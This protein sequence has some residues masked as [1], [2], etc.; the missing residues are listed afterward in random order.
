MNERCPVYPFDRTE[1]TGPPAEYRDLR[2][3]APMIKVRIWDGSCAWL[4]SRAAECQVL[5]SDPRF[6]ADNTLPGYPGPNESMTRV[7]ELYPTF[8]TMD[9]PDHDYFRR[10]LTREFTVKRVEGLRDQVRDILAGLYDELYASPGPADFIDTV[11]LA[12]P[13]TIIC[14]LLGVP[15]A[16]RKLFQDLTRVM[17]S[18]HS[19]EEDA[20]SATEQLC[21]GYLRELIRA[22]A[23]SDQ[24]E[25]ILSRLV[26]EQQLTEDQIVAL[27]RL[28]IVAGHD[29]TANMLGLT[30]FSLLTMPD[31]VPGLRTGQFTIAATVEELLRFW[32]IDNYGLRRVALED[33]EVGG[34]TVRAGEGVIAAI[35][36]ADRDESAHQ[37]PDAV[38]PDREHVR[39]H[40]AFGFGIH[41]CLGQNLARVELQ[42]SIALFLAR[43]PAL[44]LAQPADSLVFEG[45]MFNLGIEKM[46]VYSSRPR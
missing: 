34:V 32:N 15:Y 6:S 24:G 12:L 1:Q 30:A 43:T 18:G 27:G 37:C 23:R 36:S 8:V 7:R 9:N 45:H 5:L 20:R 26:R 44:E 21:E 3:S 11:A 31:L 4:A 42:E 14:Q 29:T 39:R 25:D 35:H 10:M 17:S 28:L 2:R 33:V 22:K 40:L 41:Q 19:T 13:S 46:L 38:R 16:D